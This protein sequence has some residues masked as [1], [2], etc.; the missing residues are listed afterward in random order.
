MIV[1]YVYRNDRP[2]EIKFPKTLLPATRDSFYPHHFKSLPGDNLIELCGRICYDS[3]SQEKTR[4]SVDY[5]KHINDVNHGSVQESVNITISFTEKSNDDLT[6]FCVDLMNRPGV[7]VYWEHGNKLR[8]TANIRAIREWNN[9]WNSILPRKYNYDSF[10][11]EIQRIAREICPLAMEGCTECQFNPRYPQ[12]GI[13]ESP[14]LDDEIWISYYLA[15][16]SRGLAMELIRH[17]FR[18][19]VS[20]R[21][22]R[23]VDESESDWSWHP[24]LLKYIDDEEFKNCT[25]IVASEEL[26]KENYRN[27]VCFLEGKLIAEGLDRFNAKKQSRGSA[28]GILGNALSTELIFGASLAQWKR[29][30]LQRC[31]DAADAEIRLMC[32]KVFTDLLEKYGDRFGNFVSRPAI[33]GFGLHISIQ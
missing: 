16:V 31:N 6:Y 20:M 3:C 25:R 22:T 26:A 23:Y 13:L 1:E 18:T 11:A 21:S 32:S 5:H 8:V 19:H 12:E 9:N 28:R 17:K 7:S 2:S 33:D 29:I 27:I 14:I 4:N 10:G 15:D 30:I 24:L